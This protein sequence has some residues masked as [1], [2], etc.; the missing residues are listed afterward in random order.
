VSVNPYL[1]RF[2]AEGCEF[3]VFRDGR[4]ILKGVS[5]PVEARVLY[6]RYVG[7]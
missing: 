5:D 2:S 3:T 7:S 6:S 4:A 1:L